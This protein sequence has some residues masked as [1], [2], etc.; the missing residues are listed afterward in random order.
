VN[1]CGA[2]DRLT[3]NIVP[4]RVINITTERKV[5][6]VAD[7]KSCQALC[8]M[9]EGSNCTHVVFTKA[10]ACLFFGNFAEH[11]SQFTADGTIPIAPKSGYHVAVWRCKS[12]FVS[13]VVPS[14]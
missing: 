11:K 14:A 7:L 1:L 4:D 8:L 9:E 13:P 5:V 6:E 3:W 2:E 12:K 10:S